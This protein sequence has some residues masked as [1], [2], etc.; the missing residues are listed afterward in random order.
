MAI[1]AESTDIWY[2]LRI[3]SVPLFVAG[4]FLLAGLPALLHIGSGE[5]K[6]LLYHW[7]VFTEVPAREQVSYEAFVTSVR[8]T[9]VAEAKPIESAQVLLVDQLRNLPEYHRRIEQLGAELETHAGEAD[10][11]STDF[12]RY[13]TVRPLTYEI[14]AITYNPIDRFLTGAVMSNRFVASFSVK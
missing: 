8:G 10:R 6:Y 2:R 3:Y 9:R 5:E 4:Y 7:F 12:E 14:R 1:D 13:I 11:T